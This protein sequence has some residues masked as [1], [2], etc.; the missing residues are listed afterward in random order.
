MKKRGQ[1]TAFMIIAVIIIAVFLLFY[2]SQS[3]SSKSKSSASAAKASK[4]N[5]AEAVKVYAESCI[6]KSAEEALFQR[7]G[8]QAGYINPIPEADYS[9]DGIAG[10]P[11]NPAYTSFLSKKVPYY[12]QAECDKYCGCEMCTSIPGP[13]V[14]PPFP[15]CPLANRQC[16]KW[17]CKK[18]TYKEF[19]PDVSAE[20]DLLSKKLTKYVEVE[21]EK[22]FDENVFKNIGIEVTKTN[23]KP[24]A[25][26][27][28]NEGDTSITVNQNMTVQTKDSTVRLEKFRA[29]IPIRF[30]AL[31]SD[32]LLLVDKIKASITNFPD[33][34]YTPEFSYSIAPDC[35]T[36]N[37]NGATNVYTK[38]SDDGASRIV[39]F[40]D[41]STYFGHYLLTY[42]FQFAVKNI[43]VIDNCV[44]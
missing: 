7:I 30:R 16:V 17:K 42:K 6:K 27:N 1:V 33:S 4:P 34:D 13:C 40:A 35:G 19:K 23:L 14:L 22:C 41:F 11:F 32:S 12:L 8:I 28:F 10:S 24:S 36:Y 38:P 25:E 3:S 43:N 29:D 21:F 26:I 5:T 9:E 31:Y 15:G 18:W 39:Q 2:Y 20:L 37:R 44:G